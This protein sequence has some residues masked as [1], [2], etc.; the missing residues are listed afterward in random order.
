MRRLEIVSVDDAVARIP[1]G[2]TVAIQGSGGGVG[3]PTAVIAAIARRFLADGTP[4]D[5][6]LVHATGLGDRD[7]IGTDLL[8]HPGL[9]R[10]DIAGHL[11]M[12]PRMA[13][14]IH[15][16][17]V[18]G[19]NLPQGVISHLYTAI[20]GRKPGVFTKVGLGT[21]VDPRIE[22]GRVNEIAQDTMVEVIELRGTEWLFFPAFA[23]NVAIIRGTVADTRGN[24]ATYQEAAILEAISIAQAARACGGIVIAQVKYLTEAG[25]IPAQDV[26]IPG[27]FVDCVVVDPSQKQHTLTEYDPSLSGQVRIPLDRL[28]TGELD[29]RTVIARRAARELQPGMVVNLGVGIPSHVAEVAT[30]TGVIDQITF[31][32]EQGLIG[33]RPAGGVIFG[34]AHNPEAIISEDDQFTFYD[35]GGLDIAFLG[36]AE[37]SGNGNVNVSKVG[38]ML[39]GCGGFINIT[40]NAPRVVFCGTFT[41]QGLRCSV[42]GGRLRIDQEGKTKKCVATLGQI[43]FSGEQAR[44][45]GQEV[46]YVTERAVFRLGEN[47]PILI[48]IAP[49]VDLQRDVLDLMD[50]VPEIADP[51]ATMDAS[52]FLEKPAEAATR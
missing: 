49:G 31:T 44:H 30:E 21:F 35:G 46:L 16:N 12:A 25:T 39:S 47:G 37:L 33:G 9:V 19:Y 13:R 29:V 42:G 40:Q 17:A 34:V 27:V 24:I 26:R 15:E 43:T 52:C 11:G 2:S 23:I 50:F 14:L 8:A 38:P 51:L 22:G 32:V 7:T 41:A 1:T 5:L 10:K 20:G 45:N 4:R 18:E 36:M 28:E 48:E 3:E 6:T